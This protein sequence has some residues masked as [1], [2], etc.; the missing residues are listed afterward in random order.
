[1]T[2]EEKEAFLKMVD[3]P[4]INR[5]ESHFQSSGGALRFSLNKSIA[6]DITSGWFFSF[7][8]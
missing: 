5:I 2:A 4:F 8:F 6:D 1:M 3:V 7:R